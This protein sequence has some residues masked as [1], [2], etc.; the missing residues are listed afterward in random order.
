MLLI[1][2]LAVVVRWAAGISLFGVVLCVGATILGRYIGFASAWAV[3]LARICFIWSVALGASVASHKR[4]HFA[5]SLIADKLDQQ[6]R[7]L[8]ETG[9][10]ATMIGICVLIG[11]ATR[12]SIPIASMSRLPALQVTGVWLHSAV[13]TFAVLTAIF[14]AARGFRLWKKV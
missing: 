10:I 3:E 5:M 11:W 8:V 14:L 4:L 7:R 12:E 2:R 13:T 9:L 6:W 1:D